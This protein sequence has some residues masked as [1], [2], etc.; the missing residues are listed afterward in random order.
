M[1]TTTKKGS[2]N[3]KAKLRG[4]VV[5]ASAAEQTQTIA[6]LRRELAE[7]LQRE[8]AT[9]IEN[10]RLFKELDER[11]ADFRGP[12]ASDGNGRGARHHQPLA[13]RR[14]AGARRHRRE[15]RKGLWD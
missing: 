9:A 6:E 2:K 11:N 4:P 7:S 1:A 5:K 8:S 13:H 3:K 10:V 12:G 15:R 14:A